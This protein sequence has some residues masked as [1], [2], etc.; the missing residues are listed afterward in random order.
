MTRKEFD[1]RL[2][3]ANSRLRKLKAEG[4]PRPNPTKDWSKQSEESLLEALSGR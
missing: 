1:R 4:K 3:E 2:K